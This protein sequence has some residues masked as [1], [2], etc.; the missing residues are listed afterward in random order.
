[1]IK[2]SAL[3]PDLEVINGEGVRTVDDLIVLIK[4][5]VADVVGRFIYDWLK[6]LFEGGD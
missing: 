5:I 3:P 4:M 1:M 2:S 6:H